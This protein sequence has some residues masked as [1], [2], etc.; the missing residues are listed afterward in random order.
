MLKGAG[1]SEQPL[2]ITFCAKAAEAQGESERRDRYLQQAEEEHPNA[3]LALGLDPRHVH[4]QARAGRC[5][6]D[7]ASTTAGVSTAQDRPI[8]AQRVLS[9]ST[10]GGTLL[11]ALLPQLQSKALSRSGEFSE[12]QK[13]IST[14]HCS[15]KKAKALGTDGLRL[16]KE[17]PKSLRHEPELIDALLQQLVT[18][19]VSQDA[20]EILQESLRK[21]FQPGL[22][23]LI[24]RLPHPSATLAAQVQK[25]QPQLPEAERQATLSQPTCSKKPIPK[26]NR[27]WSRLCCCNL[28]TSHSCWPWPR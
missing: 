7:P 26:P 15:P 13:Q 24:A 8:A 23:P 17:L 14:R 1:E 10:A 5:R 19:G 12:L 3:R 28:M 11:L 20:D 9:R 16:W 21:H 6:A 18:M 25:L 2:L 27:L 4:S 22:L